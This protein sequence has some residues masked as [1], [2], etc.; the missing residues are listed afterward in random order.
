M[1]AK[2]TVLKQTAVQR[3]TSAAWCQDAR[4]VGRGS[5]ARTIWT[6]ITA[7]CMGVVS[8]KEVCNYLSQGQKGKAPSIT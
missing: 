2:F 5:R 8:L 4:E 7:E 6:S 3:L 1:V